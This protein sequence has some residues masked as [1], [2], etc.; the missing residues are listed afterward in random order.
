MTLHVIAFESPIP[1]VYH[2]LPPPIE[3]LQEILAILFMGPCLPTDKDYQCTPL[4]VRHSY[5]AC[6]LEWLKLNNIYYADLEIAYNEL[7]KYPES[8]PP[9][10]VKYCHS[11]TTKIEEGTSSFDNRDEVGVDNGECP[12]VVHGLMSE[13][14]EMML[15]EALKGIAL[16]HWNNGGSALAVSHGTMS[17]LMYNNPS[18]YP[19]AFPWLFSHGLKGVGTAALSE[20]VHKHSLLMYHDKR[21]QYDVTFLFVAFSHIQMKAALSAGFLL[22]ESSKF[23]DITNRL[24]GVHQETLALISMCL[25]EGETVMPSTEDEKACFQVVHDLDYINGKVQGLITL[26]KY[27][28]SE[29]WSLIAYMG[30]P[31]W[32]IT[33]SPADNKHPICLYF[34]D[35]KESFD[36]NLSCSNDEQFWLIA[37]NPVA[38][39]RFFHFM[40][41]MFIVHVLGF[42]TD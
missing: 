20:K 3:D 36:V 2:D 37:N 1:K 4:L 16:R 31:M 39:A 29:I 28:C 6:A 14:Y 19:Q 40:I 34:A 25:S 17:K 24:L 21:F 32:Y 23:C 7:E 9:V 10:T 13:Q 35:N 30:A 27:M 38:G 18:L 33:L 12:F 41:N 15:V 26:K 11:I 5:V 8:V 22:A 42:G